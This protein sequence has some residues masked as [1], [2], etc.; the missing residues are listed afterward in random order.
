[1]NYIDCCTQ[2]DK[3]VGMVLVRWQRTPQSSNPNTSWFEVEDVAVIIA[4][5]AYGLTAAEHT[6]AFNGVSSLEDILEER[7]RHRANEGYQDDSID[8]LDAKL[9]PLPLATS[10]HQNRQMRTSTSMKYMYESNR[11]SAES[12]SDKRLASLQRARSN[13]LNP[14]ALL[15]GKLD[16][17]N[18]SAVQS[19]KLR[20][21]GI[22]HHPASKF[23]RNTSQNKYLPPATSLTTPSVY[24]SHGPVNT[25]HDT[26]T[27]A[28]STGIRRTHSAMFPLSMHRSPTTFSDAH[29]E[30]AGFAGKP[31]THSS[32]GPAI[33]M[34]PHERMMPHQFSNRP[35]PELPGAGPGSS[36]Y[37]VPVSIKHVYAEVER[38]GDL[39]QDFAS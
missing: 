13:M 25:V 18:R 23:F 10:E 17:S 2:N 35:L 20:A 11:Q 6:S 4:N 27:H 26:P 14:Y 12:T 38:K 16:Q 31:L 24:V 22:P 19:F 8:P 36:S 9:P 3:A 1:M 7:P 15:R 39:Q 28:S 29:S 37:E 33:Q 34:F 5:E 21:G 30:S 32:S